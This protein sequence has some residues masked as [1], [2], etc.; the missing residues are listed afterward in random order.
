MVLKFSGRKGL[1]ER[2]IVQNL[3]NIIIEN[4][5]DYIYI[6]RVFSNYPDNQKVDIIEIENQVRNVLA[7]TFI[8]QERTEK[9]ITLL[10][11]IYKSKNFNKIRAEILEN[12]AYN[13]GPVTQG[14]HNK[15][16]FIEPEIKDD[17]LLVGKS[18]I[19][20]DLVFYDTDMKPL[21]F[22]E[23]KTNISNVIPWNRPFCKMGKSHQDKIN[24]LRNV[25]HYL[26][27]F[28]CEPKIYFAC[29]NENYDNEK[30][31]L[32]NNWGF[33]YI[34]IISPL[35]MVNGKATKNL[36]N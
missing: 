29:Y 11:E 2:P 6:A 15:N 13:L 8:S 34:E 35:E 4:P 1:S 9:I 24:Y 22:I 12:V 30:E 10:V 14:F 21:E 3:V 33:H 5:N 25:Y 36:T 16:C 32:Q 31:N 7:M 23:C 19:K 27:E 26:N 18:N 28:Y 20:C 17:D